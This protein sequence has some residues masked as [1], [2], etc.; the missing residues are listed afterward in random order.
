MT[1]ER[2][3]VSSARMLRQSIVA[4]V[5]SDISCYSL[6]G[7]RVEE[8]ERRVFD[9]ERRL[10]LKVTN[11]RGVNENFSHVNSLMRRVKVCRAGND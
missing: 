2:A 4:V 5:K 9:E 6:G 7:C 10:S 3:R 1:C 11:L 8:K